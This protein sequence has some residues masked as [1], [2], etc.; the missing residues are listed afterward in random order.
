MIITAQFTLPGGEYLAAFNDW[1]SRKHVGDFLAAPGIASGRRFA[2]RERSGY[3]F[4]AVYEH[5]G[6]CHPRDTFASAAGLAAVAD[7]DR[8]WAARTGPP[9]IQVFRE[10]GVGDAY[11]GWPLPPPPDIA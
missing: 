3:R 2:A 1:Y 4:L 11:R 10:I 6:S 5:D 8:L 7:F 9:S